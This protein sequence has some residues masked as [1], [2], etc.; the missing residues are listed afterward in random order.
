MLVPVIGVYSGHII[1]QEP[2]GLREI[3]GLL[4]VCSSLALVLLP[5]F[6]I[7]RK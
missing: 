1:L 3:L 7:D 5:F 6:K 4:L 2:I